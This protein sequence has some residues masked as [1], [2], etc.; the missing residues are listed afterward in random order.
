[1]KTQNAMQLMALINNKSKHQKTFAYAKDIEFVD[2][3]DAVL[4]ILTMS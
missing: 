3:C 4:H 1:M 2:T